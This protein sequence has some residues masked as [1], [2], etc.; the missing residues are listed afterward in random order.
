MFLLHHVHVIWRHL[1]QTAAD[2]VDE[3]WAP[4]CSSGSIQEQGTRPR[5]RVQFL[6]GALRWK[7]AAAA[8]IPPDLLVFLCRVRLC[9]TGDWRRY[10]AGWALL[11]GTKV[12]K[13]LLIQSQ[14]KKKLNTVKLQR[15]WFFFMLNR[16][17]SSYFLCSISHNIL[18]SMKWLTTILHPSA[19]PPP[20]LV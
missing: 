12:G 15:R 14:F 4:R 11:T 17:S 3:Q 18:P 6:L 8:K 1:P 20:P 7:S 5:N 9:T 10:A 16:R 13:K 19:A 2:R